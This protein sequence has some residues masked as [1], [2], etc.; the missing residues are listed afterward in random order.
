MLAYLHPIFYIDTI[1][2][3]LINYIQMIFIRLRLLNYGSPERSI[4]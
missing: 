3:D 2:V 4:V 1:A